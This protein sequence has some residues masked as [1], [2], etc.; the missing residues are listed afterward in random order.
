MTPDEY[1]KMAVDFWC[2][3]LLRRRKRENWPWV[4]CSVRVWNEEHDT[5]RPNSCKALNMLLDSQTRAAGVIAGV[6]CIDCNGIYIRKRL[7]RKEA[8]R[9]ACHEVLH[10]AHPSWGEDKVY[11]EERRLCEEHPMP[12]PHELQVMLG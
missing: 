8:W 6:S 5:R 2:E 7:S 4:T 10:L 12:R 11:A 1:A 9:T 3:R